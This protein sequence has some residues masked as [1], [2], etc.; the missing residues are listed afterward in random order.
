MRDNPN[1]LNPTHKPFRSCHADIPE[2]CVFHFCSKALRWQHSE[3]DLLLVCCLQF[4]S[5][6]HVASMGAWAHMQDNSYKKYL[7]CLTFV[8]FL[9]G[10]SA[11]CHSAAC[12]PDATLRKQVGRYFGQ[13]PQGLQPRAERQRGIVYRSES[14]RRN[15]LFMRALKCR[16]GL[17]ACMIAGARRR[18]ASRARTCVHHHSMPLGRC[19]AE[20]WERNETPLFGWY[21]R[22]R[23]AQRSR[24]G[25]APPS[26]LALTLATRRHGPSPDVP[27]VK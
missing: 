24:R 8:F 5:L 15:Q 13:P 10:R 26:L 4:Q 25:L 1:G 12:S 19:G 20:A 22:P 23:A 21:V 11:P 7:S 2:R 6:F 3:P 18:S 9:D 16:P 27:L 14:P 17:D